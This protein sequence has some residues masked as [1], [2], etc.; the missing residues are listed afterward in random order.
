MWCGI[1]DGALSSSTSAF[2]TK[3]LMAVFSN[4]AP[5]ALLTC[6]MSLHIP[7]DPNEFFLSIF[8]SSTVKHS[9]Y[10]GTITSM[11]SDN[12]SSCIMNC[13]AAPSRCLKQALNDPVKIAVVVLPLIVY[14]AIKI[15]S[16]DA[17]TTED[18]QSYSFEYFKN[19]YRERR[20]AFR[21][22]KVANEELKHWKKKDNEYKYKE[23]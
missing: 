16:D 23:L 3:T 17:P 13:L 9:A 14:L 8:L 7:F 12:L 2:T 5:S 21:K 11:A 6:T 1:R 22:N 10:R 15:M 4:H 18:L 20:D 19:L